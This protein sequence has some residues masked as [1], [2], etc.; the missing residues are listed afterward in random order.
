MTQLILA[1]QGDSAQKA[2]RIYTATKGWVDVY[3]IGIDIFTHSGTRLINWFADQ[4]AKV[5]LDLKFADIP[6]VVARAIETCAKLKVTMFTIHT[7]GGIEMMKMCADH[8]NEFCIKKHI[9]IRPL[10]LGVTILTSISDKEFA[11]LWGT[12]GKV[13]MSV[14]ITRLASLAKKSGVDGV[15]CSAHE[16]AA[17]K[18]ECGKDFLTVVP[19]I[20]VILPESEQVEG[21]EGTKVLHDDQARFDTPEAAARLGAD[22]I[23]VGRPIIRAID[24]VAVIE[25][26]R[27]DIKKGTSNK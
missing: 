27:E 12:G 21:M 20:R 1:V 26:I 24:P 13:D 11:T 2:K 4:D 23:V 22:Y 17:I 10:I 7:M 5:F 25:K 15:V 18:K 8:L 19:G 3:K 16:V 9:K 14:H 6:T